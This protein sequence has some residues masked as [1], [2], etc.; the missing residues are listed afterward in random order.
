MSKQRKIRLYIEGSIE[1][2]TPIYI[3]QEQKNYLIKVMRC[4]LNEE[5]KIFNE[6]Y[7]EW[8]GVINNF[9]I[10]P[11]IKIRETQLEPEQKIVLCFAPTK[12]YGEFAVEK[13]TEMGV[14]CIIP[15][16]TERSIVDKINLNK[17]KKAIVEAVEQCGRIDL[18]QIT[19]L[20]NLKDLKKYIVEIYSE[21][22]PLFILCDIDKEINDLKQLKDKKI[23]CIIIGPEGGFGEK[24]YLIFDELSVSYLNLGVNVLRAETASIASVA[25]INNLIASL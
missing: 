20:I 6:L 4:R 2:N 5:I 11:I 8:I 7:G 9:Y 13:A 18:P 15:I 10:D 14:S 24:D 3:S 22:E 21:E 23:I 25:V 12:K 16:K 1:V 17:Y 19:D